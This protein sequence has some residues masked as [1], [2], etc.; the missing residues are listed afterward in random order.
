MEDLLFETYGYPALEEEVKL[1]MDYFDANHDGKISLDE[2]KTAL[3][4]M[5]NDLGK[6]D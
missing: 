5:R 6:K 1:F 2:F 3:T 4:N